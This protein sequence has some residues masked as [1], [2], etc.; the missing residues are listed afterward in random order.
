VVDALRTETI[1][2]NMGPQHPST[3]G[4]FRMIVTLDGE[5]VVEVE[6]VM[7]YLHRG[8]EKLAEENT[9]VQGVTF[10]DRMDYLS[11][12]TGNFPFVLAV[13]QLAGIEVPIRAQYL[14]VLA[15]EL[16]RIASHLCSIGFLGNDLGTWFSP[17]M[18]T[19]R[20]REA[21]LDMFEM[22]AGA[23]M[24]PTYMRP[25]GVS[26]DL[27]DGFKERCL[28]F[29]DTNMPRIMGEI[30][31]LL[32]DNEIVEIRL[33][34]VGLLTAEKAIACSV[35]G[36]SLRGSG[37]KFDVRKA[38][39]YSSYDH[40]DFDIPTGTIGDN[41]DR[42][43]VRYKEIEQSIRIVR[44]ALDTL[45]DGPVMAPG[46]PRTLRTPAGAEA[47]ARV[48]A[49]RGELSVYMASDGGVAPYRCKLRSPSFINLTALRDMLIGSRVA[50]VVVTLGTLDIVLGEV[51][52]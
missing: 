45:P 37:V 2:L 5:T 6:P 27:P 38:I 34:N 40:F 26:Q 49:S 44:K 22:L 43:V 4:V 16:Q 25:G 31:S 17:L 28:R 20:E 47:F 15:A 9:Y 10:T 1:T 41:M 8:I 42:F 32:T 13:E 52:R 46:L 11:P 12:I 30:P 3:H 50:D 19:L 51:D 35:S 23:R 7:G 36:P 39:P 29:L 48:E 24:T 21:I 33:R 18:Y 14:R